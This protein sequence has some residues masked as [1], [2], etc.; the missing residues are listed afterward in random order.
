TA[1]SCPG[2]VSM[3]MRVRAMQ[4]NREVRR[5]VGATSGRARCLADPMASHDEMREF[6]RAQALGPQ[7]GDLAA[8]LEDDDARADLDDLRHVVADENDRGPA[9]VQLADQAQHFAAFG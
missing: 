6:I 3:M 2:S 4:A 7:I 9:S 5:T 8:A 1:S